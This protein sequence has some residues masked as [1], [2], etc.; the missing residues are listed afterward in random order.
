[1]PAKLKPA[2][3]PDKERDIKGA[4]VPKKDQNYQGRTI[5][6]NN[7]YVRKVK[8]ALEIKSEILRLEY[9]EDVPDSRYVNHHKYRIACIIMSE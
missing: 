8:E 2:G 9:Q 1:M 4:F 6:S 7:A 5:Q 3:V